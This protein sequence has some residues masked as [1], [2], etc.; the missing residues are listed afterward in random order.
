M[1]GLEVCQ[2]TNERWFSASTLA[3]RVA[4]FGILNK[5]S[6]VK[7]MALSIHAWYG[8]VRD[9]NCLCALGFGRPLS[10][11]KYKDD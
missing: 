9:A 1:K 2:A 10:C 3:A 5:G 7:F 8:I 6:L 4:S 11:L